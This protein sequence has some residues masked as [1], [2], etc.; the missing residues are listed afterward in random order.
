MLCTKRKCNDE[1]PQIVKYF[2]AQ[3]NL[4]RKP[5]EYNSIVPTCKMT[6]SGVGGG[7]LRAGYLSHTGHYYDTFGRFLPE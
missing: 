4:P 1:R 5:G 2:K 6:R 3:Q 7:E